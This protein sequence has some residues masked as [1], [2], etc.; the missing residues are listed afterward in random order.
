MSDECNVMR[1]NLTRT[2]PIILW[3]KGT[4]NLIV[5]SPRKPGYNAWQQAKEDQQWPVGS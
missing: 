3:G 2:R 5:D 4:C 1:E